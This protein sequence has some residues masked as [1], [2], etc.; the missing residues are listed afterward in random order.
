MIARLSAAKTVQGVEGW[1]APPV[2]ELIKSTVTNAA[3]A[4]KETAIM[5]RAICS[6]R[7]GSFAENSTL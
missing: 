5:R 4:N 2:R 1:A 3:N 7:S 6:R